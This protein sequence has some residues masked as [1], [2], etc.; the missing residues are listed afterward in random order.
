MKINIKTK[1]MIAGMDVHL[2]QE[3]KIKTVNIMLFIQI[4]L[5]FV[6]FFYFVGPVHWKTQNTVLTVILIL[7]F[8]LMYM[9]GYKIGMRRPE[10]RTNGYLN[11]SDLIIKYFSWLAIA[12]FTINFLYFIRVM[13]MLSMGNVYDL[14]ITSI[15]DP[16]L[17]Y[18]ESGSNTILSSD[19]FGGK[20]L[21]ALIAITGPLTVGM[22][23]ITIAFFRNLNFSQKLF[24]FLNLFS[25]LSLKISTGR[26]EG[27]FTVGILAIA[28][29]ILLPSKFK[30]KSKRNTIL[31]L[32]VTLSIIILLLSLYTS[33]MLNR[34]QGSYS[35]PLGKNYVDT[36]AEILNL[37]SKSYESL[38]VYLDIYLTQG[39][40]G[41]SLATTVEWIPTFGLGYS[42]YLRNNIDGFLN[43]GI[44][45]A[46]YQTRTEIYGWGGNANWHSV[47]TWFANDI[48]FLLVP[49][50]M[51]F[52]GILLAKVYKD[53]FYNRNPIAVVLFSLLILFTFFIP[54][55]NKVFAQSETFTAFWFCLIAWQLS[56]KVKI[57]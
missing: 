9:L 50:L 15:T 33:L 7:A 57:S 32:V 18:K 8:Q 52:I 54:A 24:G 1:G 28:G 44:E 29:F 27:M 36:N 11:S 25:Y 43:L 51:L 49:I 46:S 12:S 34:T 13:S 5:L 47:Y 39:Y 4:Y 30:K 16:L 48:S 3:Y 53:A 56:G 6:L 31:K 37:F 14:F 10:R 21:A 38:I 35:L 55:N 20:L 19:M 41:M 42:S 17:L 45:N 26:S 22:V 2:Q 40:Y 23:P